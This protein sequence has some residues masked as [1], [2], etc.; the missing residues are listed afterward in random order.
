MQEGSLMLQGGN[1]GQPS[2]GP[3]EPEVPQG[4]P[5][6]LAPMAIDQRSPPRKLSRQNDGG[7]GLVPS[8]IAGEDPQLLDG[9]SEVTVERTQQATRTGYRPEAAALRTQVGHLQ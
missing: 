2:Q 4:S 3:I 1:P 6:T 8:Q 5:T 7:S 9:L